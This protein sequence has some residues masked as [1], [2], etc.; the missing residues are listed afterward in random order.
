MLSGRTQPA[1][2]RAA[3]DGR[4]PGSRRIT[5]SDF[6]FTC[7]EVAKL[8]REVLGRE[9]SLDDAQRLADL[10]EG[11]AGALVLMADKVQ[12]PRRQLAGTTAVSDTL[13]QYMACEQFEPLPDDVKEFLTRQRRPAR[14][15]TTRSST[16]CWASPTPR[17]SWPF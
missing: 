5:A 3:D 16:S 8:F 4:P 7:D 10:T 17:R 1:D 9:I 15:W 11:W 14:A 13:Y 6:S 12:P 2:R